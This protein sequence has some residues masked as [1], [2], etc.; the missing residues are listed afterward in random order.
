MTHAEIYAGDSGRVFAQLSNLKMANANGGDET[1][2]GSGSSAPSS[3][4]FDSL[5]RRIVQHREFKNAMVASSTSTCTGSSVFGTSA[6]AVLPANP[7]STLNRTPRQELQ[8]IFNRKSSNA[9]APPQFQSRTSWNPVSRCTNSN[10]RGSS[11]QSKRSPCADQEARKGKKAKNEF[12]R[13]VILL[14]TPG[15]GLVR[16]AAKAELQRLGHVIN[17]FRFCKSWRANDV[18]SKLAAAF[19]VSVPS[20]QEITGEPK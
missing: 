5:V 4:G 8:S 17:D 20:L 12:S 13:E 14:R 2:S 15:D 11:K 10:S 3:G 7:S 1:A 18:L 9:S 16:G 6:N 19:E